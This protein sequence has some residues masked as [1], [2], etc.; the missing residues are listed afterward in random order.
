MKT[1]YLV[2]LSAVDADRV[3]RRAEAMVGPGVTFPTKDVPSD[4]VAI[5]DVFVSAETD[6]GICVGNDAFTDAIQC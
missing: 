3:L 4:S 5:V 1:H 2:T 6:H